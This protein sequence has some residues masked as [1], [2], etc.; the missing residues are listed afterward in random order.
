MLKITFCLKRLP[1]MSREDFDA[2][3]RVRH[4]PLVRKHAATLGIRRYVQ[5]TPAVPELAGPAAAAR[6]APDS[7]YDGIAELWFESEAAMRAGFETAEGR[8]AGKELLEDEKRFIDLARSP[9]M[10]SAERNILV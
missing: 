3:W 8:A 1:S 6:G 4:A 10:L 7:D 9:I 2:Y 5:L